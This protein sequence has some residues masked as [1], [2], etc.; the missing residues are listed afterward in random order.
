[1]GNCCVTHVSGELELRRPEKNFERPCSSSISVTVKGQSKILDLFVLQNLLQ[2][3]P[4]SAK[5]YDWSLKYSTAKHGIAIRTFYTNVKG[6]SNTIIIVRDQRKCV[7]GAYCAEEWTFDEDVRVN[8]VPRFYGSPETFVFT[9]GPWGE[10]KKY[11]ASR[12]NTTFQSSSQDEITVGVG[13]EAAIILRENFSKCDTY[14]SSTFN[15]PPLVGSNKTNDF[16]VDTVEVW[17]HS[18]GW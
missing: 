7:F 18:V 10:L 4:E 5:L 13:N 3:C 8:G 1:M 11:R 12:K 2:H 17:G 15:S 6:V 16:N 14:S 9:V